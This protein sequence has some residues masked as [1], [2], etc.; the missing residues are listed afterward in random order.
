MYL[1]DFN[2]INLSFETIKVG[3]EVLNNWIKKID[4]FNPVSMLFEV[5]IHYK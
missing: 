3:S 4:A 5:P 1:W 2:F